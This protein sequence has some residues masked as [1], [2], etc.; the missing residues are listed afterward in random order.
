M[1][2]KIGGSKSNSSS[3]SDTQFN[4]TT[5]PIV[6]QW[7]SDLTQ[8][9]AGHVGG[10][11]DTDPQ[12]LIA[13]SNY[14]Q[15][16]AA[17]NAASLS[18]SP[19]NFD[20]A[21]DLTRSVAQDDTPSISAHVGE[22][23]NPYLNGVVNSTA[24]DLDANAGR[25]RAQQAL[26]LARSGAFGGSGAALTQS[27]TE[28]ELARARATTLSGLKSQAYSQAVSA[29]TA[30]AQLQQQQQAQRLAAANQLGGLSTAYDA[31][32]R[33]NIAAQQALGDDLR[34]VSQAQ[35]Q[36]PFTSAQQ[37]VAML[38]GLPIGLFT[39]STSS[40]TQDTQSKGTNTT[41]NASA[42]INFLPA[43]VSH[44]VSI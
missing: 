41:V 21:A 17:N 32:Q 34:G 1:S 8:N 22:F 2:L 19:W 36:A 38:Q 43:S 14:W 10:L 5:T 20:A 31:N 25:V 15:N 42:G 6:P 39:G 13:P 4:S 24:A 40:G 23:L 44:P 29:A 11:A 18:G 33:G 26:D 27:A 9:V 3:T 16:L 28:G 7:A 12:S 37:L 35:D 30:Q